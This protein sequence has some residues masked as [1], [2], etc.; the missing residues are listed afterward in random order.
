MAKKKKTGLIIVYTGDGKG[1]TTAAMGMALRGVGHGHKILMIQ[2][3]KGSWKS[4]ELE[5]VK[6]LYPYFEILPMGKGFIYPTEGRGPTSEDMMAI[7][8]AWAFFVEKL[9]SNEYDTIILD[10]INNVIHYNLLDINKVLG[11][12]TH[13]PEGLNIVLTG[14]GAHKKIIYMADLVTE[15]K[16][17]K[18]P[19]QKGV[20]AQK[21]IEY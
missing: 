3:I 2:F 1:K 11:A 9:N 14:R 20:S 18:H 13:K 10:E 17:V 4:G 19:Y 16:E 5:A 7:N 12:L 8:N 21:G 15:M 6:R